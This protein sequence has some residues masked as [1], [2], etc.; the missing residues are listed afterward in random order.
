MVANIK[1]AIFSRPEFREDTAQ[2]IDALQRGDSEQFD[3]MVVR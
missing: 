1:A 2:L 3:L